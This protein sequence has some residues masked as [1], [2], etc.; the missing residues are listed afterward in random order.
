V[1]SGG[2]RLTSLA[3]V[4]LALLATTAHAAPVH[5]VD[6]RNNWFDPP[7]VR[8]DPGDTI[9]WTLVEGV[10]TVTS[11]DGLFASGSIDQPGET[12][13]FVAPE[14][15][16]RLDYIC[17]IHGASMAGVIVV[18]EPPVPARPVEVRQVPSAAWPTLWGALDLIDPASNYRIEL[19]PG[20]HPSGGAEVGRHTRRIGNV[21]IPLPQ[22]FDLAIV[23]VGAS[24]DDVVIEDGLAF[25]QL[26][27]F[28]LERVTVR[29]GSFGAAVM[30][31]SDVHRWSLTDVVL[32]APGRFG[33]RVWKGA[34]LGS[35]RRV[36]VRDAS[37]AGIAIEGCAA[38]DVIIDEVSVASSIQGIAALNAGSVIVRDSRLT[39]NGVGVSIRTTTGEEAP[40][41]GVWIV[42]N[43]ISSSIERAGG[44]QMSATLDLPV[45]AGVWLH[46]AAFAEV[47]SNVV[48]DSSFGVVV[49][50]PAFGHAVR[51]NVFSR[52]VE[53]DLGWDGFGAAVCFAGNSS[54]DGTLTSMPPGAEA[55]YPCDLPATVG[56]PY[57]VVTELVLAWGLGFPRPV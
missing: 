18:G 57:P 16:V 6:V 14:D 48:D 38:C 42:G 7:V 27:G 26:S 36:T 2:A 54:S 11:E 39:E 40:A 33:V 25:A 15:D 41:R 8:V 30:L 45:G 52:S 32:D 28:R 13:E 9:R 43:T 49:T 51:D 1:R 21:N 20:I 46:G 3:A 47:R 17:S 34:R 10:H 19:A 44:G 37:V 53:A 24:P 31:G 23:G 29:G 12:F 35:I 50:G 22:A 56:V 55:I 5:D 4:I